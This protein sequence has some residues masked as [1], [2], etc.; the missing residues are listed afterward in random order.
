MLAH[1]MENTIKPFKTRPFQASG[2]KVAVQLRRSM[3]AEHF[4]RRLGFKGEV[5][6]KEHCGKTRAILIDTSWECHIESN[7]MGTGFLPLR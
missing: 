2:S 5:T 6:G 1:E 4:E 7:S 3:R